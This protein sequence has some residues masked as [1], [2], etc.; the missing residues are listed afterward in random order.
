M[1]SPENCEEIRSKRNLELSV[2]DQGAPVPSFFGTVD[3]GST[4]KIL[5]FAPIKNLE[6]GKVVAVL[7]TSGEH[8]YYQIISAEINKITSKNDSHLIVRCIAT[9]I[10][11][12]N[13]STKRLEQ[14]RWVPDPGVGVEEPRIISGYESEIPENYFKLGTVIGTGIPVFIDLKEVCEGNSVRL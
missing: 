4:E 2:I 7:M 8:V 11:C 10:G 1:S 5:Q 3:I 6:I 13:Q 12:F 9:Q 14:H